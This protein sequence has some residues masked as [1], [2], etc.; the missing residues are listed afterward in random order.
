MSGQSHSDSTGSSGATNTL[1]SSAR[2]RW[3]KAWV[4]AVV[5]LVVIGG[6]AAVATSIWAVL[7]LTALTVLAYNVIVAAYLAYAG[8]VQF[9]G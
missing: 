2:S 3:G 5:A 6:A 9:W 8:H 4:W 1:A 7:M